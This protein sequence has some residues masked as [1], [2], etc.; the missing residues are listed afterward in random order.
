[1]QHD[2]GVYA[3]DLMSELGEVTKGLLLASDY[4]GVIGSQTS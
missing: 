2:P 3:L 4:K 1:L